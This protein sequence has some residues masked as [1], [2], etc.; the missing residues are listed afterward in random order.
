MNGLLG[1]K[2]GMTQVWDAEGVRVAVTVLEVGP[3]PVVQVKTKDGK[4]GYDAVQVG[5]GAQKPQRL[6]K[7]VRTRFEK[8]GVAP[9]RELAEFDAEGDAVKVGDTLCVDVFDGVALVDVTA[10]T[11]GRGFAGVVRRYRMGGGP[12]GHGGHSKRRIGSIGERDLPGWIAKGKRMPGHMGAVKRTARNL[13]VV[14][15]RKDDNVLL[16]RGAVPGPAGA[17]VIVRK[18]LKKA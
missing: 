14:Q 8:A 13:A 6:T 1:K 9:C 10:V 11:K 18:A 17:T 7:A 15:V 16:V 5:F 12:H 3:C 4:D 2:V